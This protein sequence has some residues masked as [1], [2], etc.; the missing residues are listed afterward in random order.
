MFP[1]HLSKFRNRGQESS[2]LV[3]TL[4]TLVL[5][6]AILLLFFDQS[7]LNRQIS[8]SSAGQYRADV[9]AHTAVDT[10]TGDLRTEIWAGST[11]NTTSGGSNIYIP[12]AN[13]PVTNLFMVPYRVADQGY[14]NLVAQ[15]ASASNFW[16]G[17]NYTLTSPV[18]S[19]ANNR[20]ATTSANGR[21]IKFNRWNKAGLLGDPGTGP[22]PT[23]PASYAPPDWVLVTRQ[24][25]VTNAVTS[26][27]SIAALADKTSTNPNYAVGRYAY[28]IYNEGAL[29]DANVVGF[30]ETLSA[31]TFNTE[32]GLLPQVDL[33]NL[34]SL[35][36]IGDSANATNDANNLV[37]W[38]NAGTVQSP[39]NYTNY[40]FNATNGFASVA[41]AGTQI[42]V[43]GASD[44]VPPPG[45]QAFVSRQD[46]IN[47]IKSNS[48]SMTAALPFLGTSTL[49][50]DQPSYYPDPTRPKVSPTQDDITNPNVM[51]IR[52]Q[53]VF[54][55][56]SDGT[57]SVVGEPLLK[58]RFPLSRLALFQNPTA[59]ET[60]I[61][62]YFCMKQRSDGLWDY[63]DPD[64]SPPS[65][66]TQTPST[67]LPTIK[68]LA[69][70][71]STSPGREPTFWELL[72]AG[73]LTGSLGNDVA[74]HVAWS[75]AQ[76][77]SQTRQILTIGLSII[78][79]YNPDD[80]TTDTPTVINFGSSLLKYT[81][82]ENDGTT[83]YPGGTI[84]PY[85]YTST[86]S[87]PP[88][89]QLA[90]LQNL[91]VAGVENL[92][93]IMGIS[94]SFFRDT[95][96]TTAPITYQPFPY[97]TTYSNTPSNA[98]GP[99]PGI[100][101][102]GYFMFFLWNPHRNSSNSQAGTF[103]IVV[104]GETSIWADNALSEG[105]TAINSNGVHLESDVIL[106]NGTI[107]QFHTTAAAGAT[108]ARLFSTIDALKASDVD[109]NKDLPNC[110]PRDLFP[111]DPA[112]PLTPPNP[113]KEVG[114]LMGWVNIDKTD[115]QAT[116]HAPPWPFP[117]VP[118][119]WDQYNFN[120]GG[121]CDVYYP[122]D[123]IHFP[124][125]TPTQPLT[126]VLE[127]KV[128]IGATTDWIPYQIIPYYEADWGLQ[129]G[130]T[131]DTDYYIDS[132]STQMNN[133][134]FLP[135]AATSTYV[136]TSPFAPYNATYPNTPATILSFFHSD[137]RTTRFG[138]GLGN[139]HPDF[140]LINPTS[141]QPVPSASSP[142]SAPLGPFSTAGFTL[143]D[144][145]YNQASS[146][147]YQDNDTV[148]R[149]GD[150]NTANLPDSPYNYSGPDGASTPSDAQ[151]IMLNRP[152]TSVAEMGYAFRDDPWRT[153]NFSSTDS[154]DS[155]L[156]DLFCL[157]ENDN[158][159]RAGVVDV[160]NAS[161]EVLTALLANAYR[162][163]YVP[164]AGTP[165]PPSTETP[166]ATPP[167]TSAEALPIA[168]AI[169]TALGPPDAPTMVLRNVSDLPLLI[170]TIAASLPDT[171]K[172]KREAVVRS[173]ADVMNTRT[174]NL[175]IDV[176]AQSGRYTSTSKNLNDFTVEGE[177]R[178]WVH[179]AVDRFTGEVLATQIEPVVE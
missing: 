14:T 56:S 6:S 83:T 74:G 146:P 48:S 90:A 93:Y 125:E 152:F 101:L 40:V 85:P 158:A 147:H 100:Y 155:G 75:T 137:P 42:V 36:S 153:L 76:N 177:R 165:A 72:Q 167:L 13:S 46:L 66:A 84:L 63:Y 38:R 170:T 119:P 166:N 95:T 68:T 150:S 60:L 123:P 11:T 28:T 52:V 23:A 43:N 98:A 154:A 143:A 27:P 172:Y 8:F 69:Q 80:S 17:A 179:L 30:P 111:Y 102:D 132:V 59:N 133:G 55:R 77:Q 2:A 161:V 131:A 149:Q 45:D 35:P 20:T 58:H 171:F 34:L 99:V 134:T 3:I 106:N 114:I 103:R 107:L 94:H 118:Y 37:A 62:T 115:Y 126:F 160:N 71:A 47:Y 139:Q 110:D 33:A 19:A 29:L 174:W 121:G 108:P 24:G 1:K 124:A 164:T 16:V 51:S 162:D 97:P 49:A 79:Q 91:P 89:A 104:T 78:D 82:T 26:M 135:T 39:F 88:A 130:T 70:V 25:V 141:S 44:P 176:I 145:A 175:M 105:P 18:R 159:T 7:I 142:I 92:P 22:E 169:R 50:S 120:Y 157:T 96:T 112:H 138:A 5:V 73:I 140:N 148:V 64:T 178:Y 163:T 9:L 129:G 127:K 117:H 32:R 109:P 65:A 15:S 87:S 113:L 31:S 61:Q 4:A 81:S 136:P 122:N 128:Q 10:I 116:F 173:L 144:Y 53:S 168:K 57:Q 86:V 12:I 151:P 41:G 67:T 156:L 21:S 54:T